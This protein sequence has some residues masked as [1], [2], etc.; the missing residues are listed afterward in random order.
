MAAG[1]YRLYGHLAAIL[2]H[3]GDLVAERPGYWKAQ[4]QHM[5]IRATDAGG[6][7]INDNALTRGRGHLNNVHVFVATTNGFHGVV[8]LVG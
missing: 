3:T 5:Q 6:A 8:F 4:V 7:H 2:E 1:R